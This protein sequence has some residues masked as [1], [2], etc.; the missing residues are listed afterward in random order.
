MAQK[1]KRPAL[2]K[3]KRVNRRVAMV[4]TVKG[5]RVGPAGEGLPFRANL[6]NVGIAGAQICCDESPE[7]RTKISLELDSLDGNRW[8]S[9]LGRV[10]VGIHFDEVTPEQTRFLENNYALSFNTSEQ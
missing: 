2:Q 9:Y 6:V 3:N 10:A 5:R 4:K 7:N 8:V 1:K